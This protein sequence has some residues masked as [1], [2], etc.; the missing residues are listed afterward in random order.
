MSRSFLSNDLSKAHKIKRKFLRKMWHF[1]RFRIPYTPPP[2]ELQSSATSNGK[3]KETLYQQQEQLPQLLAQLQQQQEQLTSFRN[4][5]VKD[6][7]TPAT[8]PLSSFRNS[9]RNLC[10]QTAI[11]HLLQTHFHQQQYIHVTAPP[12]SETALSAFAEQLSHLQIYLHQ[13]RA[14]L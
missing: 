7:N 11:V 6:R 8:G 14:E 2:P 9:W 5:S 13:P 10:T 3:A 4:L 1:F 12:A